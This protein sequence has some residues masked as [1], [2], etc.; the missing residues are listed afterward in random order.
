MRVASYGMLSSMSLELSTVTKQQMLTLDEEMIHECGVPLEYM[1]ER[2]G[3]ALAALIQEEYGDIKCVLV[4]AGTGNNGGGGLVAARYLHDAGISVR[5]ILSRGEEMLK[6]TPK[7][8]A[9]RLTERNIAYHE[10]DLLSNA[11]ILAALEKADVC[12]DALLGYSIQ[13]APSGEALRLITLVNESGTPVVSLDFPS[14][15]HPDSGVLG[16]VAVKAD[17]TLAVAYP[18]RGHML[19][20][21]SVGALYV[22]DIGVPEEIYRMLGVS[23]PEFEGSP[24]IPAEKILHS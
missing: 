19:D 5:V 21:E 14:G 6:H 8:E 7:I 4:L 11:G 15:M 22:A 12:I 2:S 1:M 10:S 3:R 24:Y 13:G 9:L 23:P 17:K 18:K 16:E 20:R